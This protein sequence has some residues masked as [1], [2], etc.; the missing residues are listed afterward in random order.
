MVSHE[1]SQ[2]FDVLP[3]ISIDVSMR[4]M[5]V[6]VVVVI[7]VVMMICHAAL[8][9]NEPSWVCFRSVQDRMSTVRIR[10]LNQI[11]VF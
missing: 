11:V 5:I 3:M 1:L 9:F 4:S 8:L 7:L 10:S 6:I 2:K